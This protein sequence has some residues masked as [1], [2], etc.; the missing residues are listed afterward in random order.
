VPHTVRAL[1]EVTGTDLDQL[2]GALTAN[3]ERVFGSWE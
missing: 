2:C 1:A 3:A